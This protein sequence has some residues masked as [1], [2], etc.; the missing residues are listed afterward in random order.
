MTDDLN[1]LSPALDQPQ[2]ID[3]IPDDP[4]EHDQ[5][6]TI[7]LFA[8]QEIVFQADAKADLLNLF[9]PWANANYVKNVRV[10]LSAP[11]EEYFEPLVTRIYPGYQETIYGS[12]GVIVSKQLLAP[13]KSHNDRSVLWV[14]GCQAEGDRL[15]QIDIEIDWGEPLSQRM[16]D[17]LLVAQHNPRPAQGIY[18]QQNAESTRVFGNPQGRPSEVHLDDPQRATLVYYVLVNGEV[19]VPLLLTVSDVGEQMAWNGFLALRE[20]ELILEKSSRVWDKLLRAGR[21][22]TPDVQLNHAIYAGKIATVYSVQRL[23]SG[24]SPR[25]RQIE[26]MAALVDSLDVFDVTQS[27]NLLAQMRRLAEQTNGCL[28]QLVPLS[29]N[30]KSG[31][32]KYHKESLTQTT[33]PEIAS[34]SG[35]SLAQ[36]NGTYLRALAR[37]MERHFDEGLL[38]RHYTAVGLCAEMLLRLLAKPDRQDEVVSVAEALHDASQLASLYQDSDNRDRWHSASQ[39]ALSNSTE[40]NADS[41]Q[42]NHSSIAQ[43]LEESGWTT[44]EHGLRR[45]ASPIRGIA[46]AGDAIWHGC[47]LLWTKDG[48]LVNPTWPSTWTWWALLDLPIGTM[49]DEKTLSLVWDGQTLHSTQP[50]QSDYPVLLHEQIRSLNTDEDSFDLRFEF[51]DQN[52]GGTEKSD[53]SPTF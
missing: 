9:W 45:F 22:W 31:K 6:D 53:F 10:H 24:L 32:E 25:G 50:V 19:E 8:N 30:E 4:N 21:L 48:Y 40:A 23:R 2:M 36:T 46:L 42:S 44:S 1:Q 37:H 26:D 47:G 34:E 49:T 51:I 7:S 29:S 15:L 28:P 20:G 12:E 18:K 39:E 13:Q 35:D 17:G 43:Q 33:E 41:G 16:V 38:S 3:Y 5:D 52:E 11:R 14:L 27:R